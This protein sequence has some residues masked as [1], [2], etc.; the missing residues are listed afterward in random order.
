MSFS[1]PRSSG[2][3]LAP[4][5]P[6]GG[7]TPAKSSSGRHHVDQA[8][9]RVDAPGGP[10]RAR[11]VDDQRNAQQLVVELMAVLAER[12]RIAAAEVLAVVRRHDDDRVVR[13]A[14]FLERVEQPPHLGVRAADA[15]VVERADVRPLLVAD[16]GACPSGSPVAASPRT[17]GRGRRTGALPRTRAAGTGSGSRR[18]GPAGRR[19]PGAARAATRSPRRRCAR[20][21]RSPGSGAARGRVG[22]CPP[23][24][25]RRSKPRSIP[26]CRGDVAALGEGCGAPAGGAERVEQRGLERPL[27]EHGPRGVAA[28]QRDR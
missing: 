22:S 28:A 24:P 17:S 13:E 26:K 11:V 20:C 7:A 14:G 3:R 15:A 23:P 1:W 25:R 21:S 12:P 4:A 9:L 10:V 6:A 19:A 16:G 27:R 8:D 2:T 18:C 5:R